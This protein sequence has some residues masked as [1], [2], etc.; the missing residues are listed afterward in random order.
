MRD[1]DEIIVHCTATK[2]SMNIGV[3][4]VDKW[5]RQRGWNGCGYHAVIRRDGTVEYGRDYETQGAHVRGHNENT[6]GIAYAG[7]IGE[8]LEPEDN[9]TDEQEFSMLCLIEELRF[10]FGDLRVTG[11]NDYSYKACPSFKVET[12]FP[13]I[14]AF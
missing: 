4:E 2:P 6:I 3:K 9:M 10:Q 12:K 1:I 11:H 5:H 7:G 13:G 8:N 14:N